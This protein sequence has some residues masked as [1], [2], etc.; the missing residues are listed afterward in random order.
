MNNRVSG[1]VRRLTDKELQHKKE[2]GLCYRCD[3]KWNPGHQ[4]KKKEL[5]VLLMQEEER[6]ETDPQSE[7]TKI[8][9]QEITTLSGICLNSVMGLTNPKS[10]KL[11]GTI[12][13]SEVVVLIDPGATHNFLSL[14]TINQL[15]IPVIPTAEFGV[16]LGTGKAVSGT[17]KCQGILLQVQ[18]LDITEDF[19]PLTLGNSDVILGIQW[20]EK[21]GAVTTNWKTQIMK[22]QVNG[23]WV[24]LRGD[25]SLERARISLKTM[26]RTLG[27]VGGGYLVQYSQ[28]PTQDVPPAPPYLSHLV[29][30]FAKVFNW[31]GG[32]PPPRNQQHA[33]QL[34]AGVGPVSVRPYRYSYAQKTEIERLL[35]D[36]LQSGIIQPSRSPF[37][38]PVLLVKKKMGLGDFVWIIEVLTRSPLKTSFQSQL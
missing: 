21:L 34:K 38:S 17:G 25:P 6:E 37:S 12:A 23:Q 15:H 18:G 8:P 20:L 10:L 19:L 30:N 3:D 1:E 33:I 14:Q 28:A 11:K 24:T 31:K 7:E 36:M 35:R 22:F 29:W 32:L 13:E 2:K 5:S 27:A 4:C 26:V 9:P 16:S